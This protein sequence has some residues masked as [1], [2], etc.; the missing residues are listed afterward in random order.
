MTADWAALFGPL[1][2][3]VWL[4]CA[5]QAPLPR[6]A[7]AAA[8]EA[9]GWKQQP[10]ELT[11]ERF[12]GVP[13]RLRRI[14]AQLIGADPADVILA[15]SASYG[16][17]LLANGLPWSEGDEVLVMRG[18]FPSDILPWLGLASRGV[19]VRQLRPRR[20]VLQPDEIAAAIGPA[21]RV[22]CLTWVHS[23]SGWTIDLAVL[24]E[25]CRERGVTFVVNASQAVGA[26]PLD[27]AAAPV[28]AVVAVGHKWLCG[29]YATGFCWMR[30]ELR[31]TL[32]YNQLYW[33]AMLTADDLARPELDLSLKSDAGARQYDVFGTANFFNFHTW[34]ASLELLLA[35]GIEPITAYDDTLVDRL[36]HGLDRS[37]YDLLTPEAGPQ[38]STLVFVAPKDR[39]RADAVHAALTTEGVYAARRA[40]AL[41]FAPHLYNTVEEIDRA[42][43]VLNA[44]G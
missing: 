1:G 15:N 35:I 28:D 43:A 16:L 26:R 32:R 34:A 40:G 7:V 20:L 25:L 39:S 18:D 8:H 41:R 21:T 33:L 12:A 24:G 10:W 29:P 37:R 22:L 5:H 44:I 31:R 6:T 17:H 11:T 23:L 38:R 9:V 4:D 27:I 14:I 3:R 30:P 13:D 2:G 19:T 36:V 42:L